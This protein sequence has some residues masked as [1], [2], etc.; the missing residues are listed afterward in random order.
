MAADM[1]VVR[2]GGRDEFVKF[3]GTAQARVGVG[4]ARGDHVYVLNVLD[5]GNL[6]E[7]VRGHGLALEHVEHVFPCPGQTAAIVQRDVD[8]D[9]LLRKRN[10]AGHLVLNLTVGHRAILPVYGIIAVAVFG[11]DDFGPGQLH[12]HIVRT[13]VE[14]L[15]RPGRGD[16]AIGAV[17]C[18]HID[19]LTGDTDFDG[20]GQFACVQDHMA[21]LLRSLYGFRRYR[22]EHVAAEV[23]CVVSHRGAGLC[24]LD[25]DELLV[26]KLKLFHEGCAGGGVV[27]FN[28]VHAEHRAG[29][30]EA[31]LEGYFQRVHR[32]G[33]EYAVC[34]HLAGD[35][36]GI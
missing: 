1:D 5:E 10:V 6:G 4:G 35:R 13:T 25:G 29:D 33:V 30:L 24:L 34:A 26:V 12:I 23:V 31:H 16:F 36:R 27:D 28:D 21:V 7:V 17:G 2:L 15:V 8:E 11:Q 19:V 14:V 3:L 32:H 18:F 9:T 22:A 20:G